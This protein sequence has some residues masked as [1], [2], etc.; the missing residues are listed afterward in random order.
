MSAA[1]KNARSETRSRPPNHS[2]HQHP[3]AERVHPPQSA[4][5]V[6]SPRR[7]QRKRSSS[8]IQNHPS[9]TPPFHVP[10]ARR[11]RR[12]RTIHH[13]Q[14]VDGAGQGRAP[15]HGAASRA[16][17]RCRGKK[18]DHRGGE[19]VQ[20]RRE[21][22][23]RQAVAKGRARRVARGR[24]RSLA[25]QTRSARKTR[26]VKCALNRPSSSTIVR[27]FKCNIIRFQLV[28]RDKYF[29]RLMF[30]KFQNRVPAW[31]PWSA[32][33]V[34]HPMVTGERCSSPTIPPICLDSSFRCA[35]CGAS[36]RCQRASPTAPSGQWRTRP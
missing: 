30:Q 24:D 26:P 6:P 23:V 9:P 33:S 12:G 17:R 7:D 15:T 22:S 13:P 34:A 4:P 29:V 3:A 27:Q 10:G 14:L 1:P 16:A 28:D 5:T 20:K 31:S 11:R 36:H 19:S 18:G 2:A 35:Y 8:V 25:R 32:W 21:H